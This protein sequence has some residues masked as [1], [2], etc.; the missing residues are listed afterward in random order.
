MR[1]SATSPCHCSFYPFLRIHYFTTILSCSLSMSPCLNLMWGLVHGCIKFF[2][3]LPLLL[4]LPLNSLS[5][6]FLFLWVSIR[7]TSSLASLFR[8]N[9]KVWYRYGRLT[10]MSS[11]WCRLWDQDT[12][13][14]CCGQ[15]P[16]T[17]EPSLQF[18]QPTA[19]LLPPQLVVRCSLM[20]SSNCVRHSWVIATH[21]PPPAHLVIQ[22]SFVHSEQNIIDVAFVAT[23]PSCQ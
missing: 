20:C 19:F 11:F 22:V 14:C 9:L 23:P 2:L 15:A 6:F 21:Q 1:L 8:Q 13:R 18:S 5:H 16:P 3:L 12:S 10:A 4:L 7:S 17:N